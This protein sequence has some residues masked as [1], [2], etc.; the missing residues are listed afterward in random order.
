MNSMHVMRRAARLVVLP[1]L[2]LTMSLIPVAVNSA[3]KTQTQAQIDKAYSDYLAKHRSQKVSFGNNVDVKGKMLDLAKTFVDKVGIDNK[4][5]DAVRSQLMANIELAEADGKINGMT[6]DDIMRFVAKSAL[7]FAKQQALDKLNLTSESKK[8]LLENA[9]NIADVG[10]QAAGTAAGDGPW[11]DIGEQLATGAI[12]TLCPQCAIARKAVLVAI[13]GG[14]WAEAWLQ[15]DILARDFA[16]WE[17][18]PNGITPGI[19]A[20]HSEIYTSARAALELG[21]DQGPD[22]GPDRCLHCREF[23]ALE[24]GKG[25]ERSRGRHHGEGAESLCRS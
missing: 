23:R 7:P 8:W 22:H 11:R 3:T 1:L 19:L 18:D 9:A 2:A 21:W 15:D 6:G 5:W 10:T 4:K 25:Q 12:D 24:S 14:K 17:N 20:G 13:E 16:N